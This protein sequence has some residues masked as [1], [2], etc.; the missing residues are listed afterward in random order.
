MGST[1]SHYRGVKSTTEPGRCSSCLLRS[2]NARII[3]LV[4]KDSPTV[5]DCRHVWI[6]LVRGFD[7]RAAGDGN[8]SRDGCA[9]ESLEPLR[10]P[11]LHEW[12]AR[13]NETV[14]VSGDSVTRGWQTVLDR[15]KKKYTNANAMGQLRFSDVHVT[16]L[17][18]DAAVV[19][20]KW[21]LALPGNEHPH[22]RFTLIFRHL[23]DGWRIVHD[24]TSVANPNK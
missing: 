13:S 12:L 11:G 4:A 21:T 15:D 9:G 22:G 7:L 2:T 16:A 3:S 19:L 8:T 18:E 1:C 5:A 24:H 10:H 6:N 14:F 23:H 20:G 17:G